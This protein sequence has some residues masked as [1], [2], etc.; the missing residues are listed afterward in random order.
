MDSLFIPAILIE[1][2]RREEWR[3]QSGIFEIFSGSI[4]SRISGT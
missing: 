3:E 2:M 4:P 1:P